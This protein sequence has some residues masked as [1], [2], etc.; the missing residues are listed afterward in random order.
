ML[1]FGIRHWP[2]LGI[3]KLMYFVANC[4]AELSTQYSSANI[5]LYLV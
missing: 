1:G 4:A 2:G 3:E 5:R